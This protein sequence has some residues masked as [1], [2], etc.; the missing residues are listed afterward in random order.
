MF[1]M[2]TGVS[3]VHV[4]Y[5]GVAPMLVDLL[6]GQVQGAVDTLPTSLPHIRAGKLR[7]L[8]VCSV[9]RSAFLPDVPSMSEFLPGFE[10]AAWNAIAAP[11]NTPAAIINRLNAELEKGFAEPKLKARI[12]D[13]GADP[14]KVS[15]SELTKMTLDGIT[16]WEKVV[17]F[18]NI[19]PE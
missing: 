16:K 1:K 4:P 2:Q 6:A 18:A 19:K 11:K 3:M 17:R 9:K 7:A 10:A 14:M 5:R 15:P 12:T 13:M 8:A